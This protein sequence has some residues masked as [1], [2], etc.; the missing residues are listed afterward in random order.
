MHV[1]EYSYIVDTQT[2]DAMIWHVCM[3]VSTCVVGVCM[4]AQNHHS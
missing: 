3:H 2:V 4:H 1:Y